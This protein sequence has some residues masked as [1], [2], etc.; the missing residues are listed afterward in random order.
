MHS[1]WAIANRQWLAK[2]H[3]T[4]EFDL[5]RSHFMRLV[6]N[7]PSP[8]SSIVRFSPAIEY[9]KQYFPGLYKTHPQLFIQINRLTTSIAWA[10][11][12]DTSPYADLA[13]ESIHSDLEPTFVKEYCAKLAMSRH[14]PLSVVTDIG[15]NG[16]LAKIEKSKKIMRD[17][18]DQW[19]VGDELM[20]CTSFSLSQNRD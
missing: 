2:R 9:S 10:N 7:P 15:A 14:P 12:L 18:R 6:T 3:S 19:E 11:K 5:H 13:S 20:V 1:R 17:K 4:F 16:A 8:S